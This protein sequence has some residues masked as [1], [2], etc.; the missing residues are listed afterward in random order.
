MNWTAERRAKLRLAR[1]PGIGPL[2]FQNLL[3]AY[4]SAEAA[5]EDLPA[6]A[7]KAGRKNLAIPALAFIDRE[8]EQ[9]EAF[10][11]FI[12]FP[13]EDAFPALLGQLS[14]PP[15]VLTFKGNPGL[16]GQTT[17]A[18]VG[19]R[20]ASAAGIRIAGDLARDLGRSGWT[21]V[22]GLARGIDRA[23]HQGALE[24]GTVAVIAGGIDNI[25]PPQNSDLFNEISERGLI[26]SENP[27]GFEPRARDFP[28]RNR[29]ITGLA[30]G[31][32]VVEA[33]LKSGSLIS[34]RTA[35]EQG[36][37]VM[38]VP[39][40]PLDPRSRGSN[41][42]IRSGATLVETDAHVLDVVS[43]M[44]PVQR[45][46]FQDIP[47]GF[48]HDAERSDQDPQ[49][50]LSY[51]S[52]VAVTISDLARAAQIPAHQCAGLLVDLELSGQAITLPGGLV[53]KRV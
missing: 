19:A 28:R 40:S 50:L 7:R 26:L 24:T 42:L 16:A 32:V 41:A 25:Y 31:V 5:L 35:L 23:A 52:P 45:D 51:L 10:G 29:L 53:Q 15:P 6:R 22:S 30:L 47:P 36:R 44:T 37:E 33:A 14:P 39:G 48:D 13:G 43:A 2:T 34:A 27:F 11:A 46:L 18:I 49:T 1:T 4:P 9:T 20:N 12:T 38:A 3:A 8:I 17:L 21:I